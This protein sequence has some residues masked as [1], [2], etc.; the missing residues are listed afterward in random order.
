MEIDT[1]E[2][3]LTK[4][5]FVCP[6]LGLVPLR[7]VPTRRGSIYNMSLCR[8]GAVRLGRDLQS[9]IRVVLNRNA[10]KLKGNE[11]HRFVKTGLWDG[12]FALSRRG[13]PENGTL[14]DTPLSMNPAS[15]W[16]NC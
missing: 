13:A 4:P 12:S 2:T 8:E 6:P 5:S 11:E 10:S 14:P 3:N 16:S 1:C 9:G 7:N 15:P